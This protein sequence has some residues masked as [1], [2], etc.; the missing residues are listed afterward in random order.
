MARVASLGTILLL[1]AGTPRPTGPELYGA[2]L[3]STG[4][5]D[6]FMA[7]ARDQRRVLFCRAN[8]D[9]SA[10]DI[11]ETEREPDQRW[12]APVPRVENL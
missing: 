12:R 4:Q 9:F 3:F 10:Y 5:W 11:Y 7:F 8:D 2:G 1:L 6:F